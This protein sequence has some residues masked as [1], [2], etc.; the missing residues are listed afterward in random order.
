MEVKKDR[1]KDRQNQSPFK[2]YKVTKNWHFKNCCLLTVSADITFINQGIKIASHDIIVGKFGVFGL[3]VPSGIT[4]TYGTITLK[5]TKP[6][7]LFDWKY[8]N[9][10]YCYRLL[11][12]PMTS[13]I[14]FRHKNHHAYF[15]RCFT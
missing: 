12:K 9:I 11:R 15:L 13:A 14:I 3:K 1:Q 4:T 7:F 6:N 5:S 8:G 2:N 10:M